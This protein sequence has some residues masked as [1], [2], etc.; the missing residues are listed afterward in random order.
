MIHEEYKDLWERK[1]KNFKRVQ[2]DQGIVLFLDCKDV[3][4][5]HKKYHMLDRDP[6]YRHMADSAYHV[7]QET[8][9]SCLI[10]SAVDETSVIFQDPKDLIGYFRVGNCLDYILS[11]YTQR[12]LKYFWKD[13][14]EI[15][16]KATAF[17]LPEDE[18]GRYLTWRESVCCAVAETYVAKEYLPA[19]R[20]AG[21]PFGDHAM[22]T[23]LEEEGLYDRLEQAPGFLHGIRKKYQA[24]CFGGLFA[25]NFF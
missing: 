2:M 3:T 20:Y 22:Q 1:E 16:V 18:I 14:P 15:F 4:R 5:N 17:P 7:A 23:L 13:Y 6:I 9:L 19:S 21:I 8:D 12:F 11:L 10:Y 25:E 24:T